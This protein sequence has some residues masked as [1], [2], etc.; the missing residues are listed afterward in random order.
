MMLNGTLK[1][2]RSLYVKFVVPNW[3]PNLPTGSICGHIKLQRRNLH[4]HPHLT[5]IHQVL[6][7]DG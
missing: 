4:P 3:V 1:K 5:L 7:M 6:D 2:E